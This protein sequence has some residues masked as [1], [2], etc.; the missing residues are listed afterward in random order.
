MLTL[1]E[2]MEITKC[3]LKDL[4]DL[5]KVCRTTFY[6]TFSDSNTESDMKK[7]LE[8]AYS[9]EKLK[10]ELMNKESTTFLAK[11]NGEV[12]GFLKL[13]SGSA[14][15]EKKFESAL[16]IQRIYIL[17]KAKGRGIGTAFMN[18]AEKKARELN[19]T[20]IWL[21]VWEHNEAAKAFYKK[22]GFTRFSEHTFTVGTDPQTDWLLKK[23]IQAQKH[24]ATA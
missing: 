2:P 15:T 13:N 8:D 23:E 19:V 11:E 24:A 10:E 5:Q 6:E 14:Q 1:G 4:D 3:T 12:L 21:G 9:A 20:V 17:K 16:E 18:L 7:F 22:K